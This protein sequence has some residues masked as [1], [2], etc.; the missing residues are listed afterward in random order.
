M[1]KKA[2]VLVV[3]LA[4][5]VL[6]GTLWL[7]MRL[8]MR[9]AGQVAAVSPVAG[10]SGS[11]IPLPPPAAPA[12]QLNQM[13]PP[14]AT[15]PGGPNAA[16]SGMQGS[17]AQ[18][19]RQKQIAE[20]RTMQVA[21]MKSMQE[22]QRA[23]PKQVDALLVK[24]KQVTGTSMV[25]GIDIDALRGHLARAVEIQRIAEEMNREATRPGGADPKKIKAYADQLQALQQKNMAAPL[26]QPKPLAGPGK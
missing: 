10:R 14:W 16:M 5:A 9:S 22:T 12:L 4:L 11:N 3:L 26:L 15:P 1:S 20:L 6:M 23:D 13:A 17:P 8:G 19:E 21:L 25:N 7:G 2:I 24:I 18:I